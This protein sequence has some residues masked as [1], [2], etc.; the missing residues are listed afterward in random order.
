MRRKN[1]AGTGDEIGGKVIRFG[2]NRRAHEFDCWS[3]NPTSLASIALRHN[4]AES[5]TLK[6][7]FACFE[8]T[9]TEK[10]FGE[11]VDA[12]F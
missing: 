4:S 5:F 12:N 6:V 8:Q 9:E 3:R 10:K 11:K 1:L 7:Q 2:P